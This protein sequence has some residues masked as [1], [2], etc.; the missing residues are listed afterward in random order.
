MEEQAK[1][2]ADLTAAISSMNAKLDE[3]HPAVLE[4][5]TW[6]PTI[7]HSM[8]ALRAEVGDLRSRVI[9]VTRSTSSSPKGAVL[10][11]SLQ[12]SADAPPTSSTPAKPAVVFSGAVADE[13]SGDGHGDA[14]NLRGHISGDPE[15]SDGA[16]A[17]GKQIT[18]CPAYDSSDWY[19]RGYTSSRFPP[20]PHVDF[21]LFDGD[22]PC[23][24]HFKCEAY[25][26]VCAMNPATWVNCAAM[27]FMDD[28]LAWL[29]A[30]KA[31]LQFPVWK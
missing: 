9:D 20:P 1:L 5:H 3:M 13:D 4:L 23:A 27:Y 16:P 24:C 12:F 8:E 14:S 7:E 6:K 26:Q 21:P 2:L 28:A 18:P 15:S 30:S 29:Q 10:P 11:S 17:K 22:N 31:H 19:G 25:F